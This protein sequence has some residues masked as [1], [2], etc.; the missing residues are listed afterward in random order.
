MTKKMTITLEDDIIDAVASFAATTG[1]KKTQVIR[2]ALQSYLPTSK[3][4]QEDLWKSQNQ[5]KITL[6]NKRIEEE[7]TFSDSLRSF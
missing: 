1:K 4:E 3:Q 7:G 2:E 6:Y 5:D